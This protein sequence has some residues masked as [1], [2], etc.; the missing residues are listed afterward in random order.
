VIGEVRRGF[1]QNIA[2][3]SDTLQ[4][5]LK[6]LDLGLV[7]VVGMVLISKRTVLLQPGIQAMCDG[8][9][10]PRHFRNTVTTF[11]ELLNRFDFEFFRITLAT[12]KQLSCSHFL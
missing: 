6:P 4:F 12:Y 10:P 7:I 2:L 1:F 5:L 9:Q 3:F 8:T 11:R